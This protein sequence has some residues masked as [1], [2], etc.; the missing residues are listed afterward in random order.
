M[1]E[2]F[3]IAESEIDE[4]S[5]PDSLEKWDSLGHMKLVIALEEEF[6]VRF[7][8]DDIV[9]MISFPLIKVALKK[10]LKNA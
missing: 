2:I 4:N 7:S 9:E 6:G 3:K 10:H 1:S 8:H 5:S